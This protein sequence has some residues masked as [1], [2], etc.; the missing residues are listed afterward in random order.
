MENFSD[1]LRTK[2]K[3]PAY[4]YRQDSFLLFLKMPKR[5]YKERPTVKDYVKYTEKDLEEMAM[6]IRKKENGKIRNEYDIHIKNGFILANKEKEGVSVKNITDALQ[7]IP[8]KVWE[9]KG[10]EREEFLINASWSSGYFINIGKDIKT[11][12]TIF[13]E[14]SNQSGSEKNIIMV[15]P[16]SKVTITE[17]IFS[18]NQEESKCVHG[19]TTYLFLD[20][21]A[22]VDYNYL[23]DKNQA[24]IDFT[25]IR[26]FQEKETTFKIF[27]VN[28]GSG[29]VLFCTE[30]YQKGENSDYRVFGASFSDADQEIDIRDNTFEVGKHCAADVQVRGVV[31]GR[32]STIHRGNVDIEL[33]STDTTGFYDS[34]ILLL[35]KEGY[36]NSKPGLQI[37]NANTRSKH[38]SAIS[39]VDSEQILYLESRGIGHKD[40]INLITGGFIGSLIERSSN[41]KFQEIV[42]KYAEGISL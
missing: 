15:G 20:Q 28:H 41:R 37:K 17:E 9:Q 2:L 18:E 22:S 33:E 12:I 7:E 8:E 1:I 42:E 19:K 16:F 11:D 26:T 35:S 40:A 29:K 3:D 4:D 14:E 10:K 34:R 30:S 27:H 5:N 39:S 25:F 23:Q 36:A 6:G 21:G 13:S 32:S 24:V 38:G 31:T